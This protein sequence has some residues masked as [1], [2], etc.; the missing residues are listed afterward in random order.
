MLLWKGF[1]FRLAFPRQTE[2]SASTIRETSPLFMAVIPGT[3]YAAAKGIGCFVLP[4]KGFAFRLRLER[5]ACQSKVLRGRGA[6]TLATRMRVCFSKIQGSH[7][8]ILYCFN[9]ETEGRRR[10][11]Q[12]GMDSTKS[13]LAS[14][15]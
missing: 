8:H 5:C 9:G 11:G 12:G 4:S 2:T 13:V 15:R 3:A 1:A 10:E 6:H 14:Q 7:A